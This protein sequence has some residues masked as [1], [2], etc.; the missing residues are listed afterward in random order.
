MK[1]YKG[2]GKTLVIKNVCIFTN[3]LLN[4]GAEKQAVLLAKALQGKYHVWLVVYYGDKKEQKFLDIIEKCNLK[5]IYLS[6]SHLKRFLSFYEFLRRESINII[7]SYLLTTN[8]IGGLIGKIAGVK[9]TIGGIRNAELSKKKLALQR[10]LQNYI[11]DF[12]IYNNYCGYK[13][14]SFK[15][16]KNK[17][18]LII[19]NGFQLTNDQILR[20]KQSFITII[21]VGRF[22]EQKDYYT[23][24]NAVSRL[25]RE[26]EKFIYIIIG[27]GRLE[28]QIHDWVN[29]FNAS[30][31]IRV[32]INPQNL[33][34]YYKKADIYL[35]TSIFEG[36]SNT[37]LEAMSFSLPLVITYVGDN[38]KLVVD[39]DNG[40]L[41]NP[42]NSN[43][44]ADCL[45]DLCSSYNKRI[46]FGKRS[47]GI[48]K[49]NYSYEKFQE[50]YINFIEALEV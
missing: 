11:N 25:R 39:G 26:F 50:R 37:V 16:F 2:K 32:I 28:N 13:E 23:A 38:D 44:I 14:L 6:G 12:A 8:L 45:L 15:G 43:Q 47:Y 24:I 1:Y 33:N 31:Y 48:L 10:I 19:P 9:Y 18:A 35:M 46:Q 27:Y 17:K 49:E 22:Q 40:F 4:G 3:T 41:C 7:F 30:D 36:L 29:R 5:A 34:D 20:K 21:S 42:K